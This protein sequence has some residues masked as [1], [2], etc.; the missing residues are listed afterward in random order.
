MKTFKAISAAFVLALSL[1]IPAYAD[2]A[3]GD[4]HSPGSY[5]PAP[6]AIGTPTTEAGDT[7]LAGGAPAIVGDIS[8]L[9][10]ADILWALA[11]TY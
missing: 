7:D 9:N 11:S 4:G 1:S 10:I 2:T 8:F 6:G 5:V 3:P